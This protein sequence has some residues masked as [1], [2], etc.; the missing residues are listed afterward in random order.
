MFNRKSNGGPLKGKHVVVTGGARGIGLATAKSFLE[1][2][3]KISIGDLDVSQAQ[4]AIRGADVFTAA[5]DVRDRLQMQA[6]VDSARNHHGPVDVMINNAGIMPTGAFHESD[7]ELDDAQIDINLRGVIHGCR[8]VL[9]QMLERGEG[10][11]INLASLAGRFAVPGL[12]VYCATKFAVVGL[13]ESLAAEYGKTNLEFSA[14]MPAKVRTELA[15]GTDDADTGLPTVDPEDIAAAIVA[16]VLKP[17]LFVA[18]PQ[19]MENASLMYRMLPGR[20]ARLGRRLIGDDRI[21]RKLNGAER[22]SY[23]ARIQKLTEHKPSELEA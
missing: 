4:A 13:T 6:F 17:R 7:P 22:S 21:L 8:A 9:P 15:A 20:V 16:T 10:H 3:A 18:I 5:L 1:A 2:G 12:A 14:I 11:I 23:V 19:Y